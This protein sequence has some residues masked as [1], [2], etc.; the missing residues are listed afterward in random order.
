MIGF[1]TVLGVY[2]PDNVRTIRIPNVS[3]GLIPLGRQGHLYRGTW[4][5]RDIIPGCW[6][7]IVVSKLALDILMAILTNT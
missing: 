2:V 7:D 6:D 5:S 3:Q 1:S 4:S